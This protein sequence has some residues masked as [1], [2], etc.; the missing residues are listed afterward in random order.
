MYE[1][2]EQENKAIA[3]LQNEV[4]NWEEG[5]VSVTDRYSFMMKN[6]IKKARKN[7]FGVFDV[8]KDPVTGRKKLFVP[9]TEWIVEDIVKNIDIDTNDIKVKAKNYD[10][11]GIASMFRYVL[12][13][14]LDRIKFGKLINTVIRMMSIDGTCYVKTWKEGREIKARVIDCLNI[15]ADPSAN[16][17]DET[18][19]IERN[20]LFLPEFKD[21]G[22]IGKWANVGDVYGSEVI[23]RSGFDIASRGSIVSEIPMVD[24]YER[25][26]WMEKCLLT[27]KESD[28]GEY[29]YGL[30]VASGLKDKVPVCH[31]IKE[32]KDHP[33]TIFKFKDIWN[34][35]A[36]RGVAEMLFSLQAQINETV[37]IR[38]NTAR[39]AQT[40]LWKAR[41]GVSPQQVSKLFST[42]V[43]KLKGARD[44]FD[45]LD[46][47][48]VDPSSYK[49]EE[50]AKDWATKV[51]GS[52]DNSNISASTPATNSLIQERGSKIGFNLVQENVGLSIKEML[53]KKLI[54][55][56]N[57]VIRPGDIIR[58]TG[59]SKDFEL[60]EDKYIK[61]AVY[62]KANDAINSGLILM[63]GEMEAEIDRMKEEFKTMGGD[64]YLAI[65]DNAFNTDYDIDIAI[66]DEELNPALIVQSMT[67]ALGI[68]AQFP[69]SKLDVDEVMKEIMDSLGLDGN[70]FIQ[71]PE[72][73]G[74]AQARQEQMA[75]TE[76]PGIQA[77]GN[78]EAIL[79]PT[80]GSRPVV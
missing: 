63:P 71:A 73:L 39:I 6:V 5:E 1:P 61:N 4:T 32:V 58:I 57:K 56:I 69:G 7:Y 16:N 70:R 46:S 80:P 13:Y 52:F 17:L 14:Y 25:Y 48:S 54:P 75:N 22:K 40:G 26:G 65:T 28:D 78:N 34:R 47:G 11:H 8:E 3:L 50:F 24:V 43:I 51:T 38:R 76:I 21:E 55:L 66:G 37:N 72:D 41:G 27:G 36:G 10:S 19:I 53:E 62:Q 59:N 23:D 42:S 35:L 49:D 12:K 67:Q 33:Y 31:L 15:I 18:P 20:V 68:M 60:Q 29:V 9:L 79:N 74:T 64:R 45:R 2:N 44:E 77:P 30:I